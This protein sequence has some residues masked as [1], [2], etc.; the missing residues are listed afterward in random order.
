MKVKVV[1]DNS[2][3]RI[4]VKWDE[5]K[6]AI[7]TE[8]KDGYGITSTV[9]NPREMLDIVKFAGECGGKQ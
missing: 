1:T 7:I 9:L 6:F 8:R 2:S 4:T 5:V 3:E